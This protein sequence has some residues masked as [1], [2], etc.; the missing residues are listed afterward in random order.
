MVLGV[1]S[2]RRSAARKA[3]TSW[4]HAGKGGRFRRAHQSHQART[5]RSV[6]L[7]GVFRLGHALIGFGGGAFGAER[8]VHLRLGDLDGVVEPGADLFRVGADW[9]RR[10]EQGRSGQQRYFAAFNS[11]VRLQMAVHDAL[12]SPSVE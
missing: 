4:P 9:G 2:R 6:G 5:R 11:V 12:R 3:A 8:A 10:Q 1:I 7:A